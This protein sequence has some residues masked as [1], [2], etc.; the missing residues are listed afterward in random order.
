MTS[1]LLYFAWITVGA[2]PQVQGPTLYQQV[3]PQTTGRNGYEEY[4][5]AADLINSPFVDLYSRWAPNRV[6]MTLDPE[7]PPADRPLAL[8]R[9]KLFNTLRLQNF[10]QVQRGY[11]AQFPKVVDLIKL[12]NSKPVM[13]PRTEATQNVAPELGPFREIS[14]LIAADAYVRFADGGTG[15][16]TDDLLAGLLFARNVGQGSI[17]GSIVAGSIN[18]M[19]LSGFERHFESMSQKD[20]QRITAIADAAVIE[21]SGSAAIARERL[22]APSRIDIVLGDPD[23]FIRSL[24]QTDEGPDPAWAAAMKAATPAQKQNWRT[25]YLAVAQSVFDRLEALERRP[26]SE[27]QDVNAIA[28]PDAYEGEDPIVKLLLTGTMSVFGQHFAYA[29]RERTQFRL[30]GLHGRI[31]DYRWEN[32]TLPNS[33]ADAVPEKLLHDPLNGGLFRYER[34]GADYRVYSTGSPATGEVE[35]R[36]RHTPNPADKPLPPAVNSR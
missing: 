2:F 13:D 4:V 35:I 21:P 32:G 29:A 27:W 1:S 23:A 31:L 15:T 3:I 25:R 36:Y 19:I 10:L 18:Q 20:C 9:I 11:I 16:G 8:Q 7:T 33:L 17:L 28:S 26:E 6:G 14:R 22:L 12:G 24:G 34:N 30:L 5:R